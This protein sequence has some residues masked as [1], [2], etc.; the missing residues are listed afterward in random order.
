MRC[1]GSRRPRIR[2]GIGLARGLR[3]IAQRRGQVLDD[4]EHWW[5]L[6]RDGAE[7]AETK[8]VPAAWSPV[9]LLRTKDFAALSDAEI[10]DAPAAVAGHSEL[11][12]VVAYLQALGKNAPKG[13]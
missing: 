9:E 12:A 1:S 8:P 6:C 11:D 7:P 4:L 5:T 3:G 13:D 10:A 2:R